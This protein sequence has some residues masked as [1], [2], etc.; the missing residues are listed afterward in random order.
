MNNLFVRNFVSNF[1]TAALVLNTISFAQQL[2][3]GK[4]I[5]IMFPQQD[6]PVTL[7]TMMTGTAA[8]P[9]LTIHLPDDYDS[10]KTYPLLV[11]VPGF[12]G[13]PKG[14]IGNAQTIAGPKGWIVATVPLFKDSIDKSEPGGGIIIGF[15]DYPIISRA[16]RIILGKIFELVP[17]ID[18]AKS[19]LVGF[20]NGALTIAVL[21]SNQDEFILT[22]F[23]NFCIIDHGMFHLTDL[24]KKNARDCRF[25]VL[26]G[27]KKDYGRNLKIKGSQLLQEEW[28][29]LG[30][31]LKCQ[32]MEDTGHEFYNR[33]MA[34]VGLW[35]R[36]EDISKSP[37]LKDTIP[38]NR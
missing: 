29:S 1:F 14:N 22:H 9:C 36:N 25:L 10:T 38:P 20:S 27:D 24:H 6:L 35:L 30:V 26:V 17:N 2:T 21:V 33:Q 3:P 4:N 19:A 16:Y 5:E 32:I 31:N 18:R 12:H 23:K 13:G 15:E 28:K 7:F 34:L 37:A 8:A 11:Y